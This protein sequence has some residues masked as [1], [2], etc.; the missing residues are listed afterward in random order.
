MPAVYEGRSPVLEVER[1]IK[2][3]SGITA[4]DDISFA[5]MPGETLGIIGPNGAGKT[6]L[7][8]L[9]S[10]LYTA[11]S[12]TIR[13]VGQDIAGLPLHR[14]SRLGVARTFQNI[15]ILR[16]L[17]VLENV[18]AA[19]QRHLRRPLRSVL[20]FGRQ[21]AAIDRAMRYIELMGLAALVN[22]PAGSLPYGLARRLEIARALATEPKLLLLDEPAA[23]MNEEETAELIED[24]RRARTMVQAI[25]LIEHDMSLISA[26]ADRVIGVNFGKIM[27][28]GDVPAVLAHPDVQRAYL[29]ADEC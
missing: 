7:I 18:L 21:R 5:V 3:F 14:I 1:V 2:R 17:S 15:R 13:I 22:R 12:G 9:V 26:L 23:G 16:R 4:V 25:V 19:D 29:G 10:G 11:T 27:A 6:V 20:A 24:V 8:N 28:Q